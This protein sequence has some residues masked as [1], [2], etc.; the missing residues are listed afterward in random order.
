MVSAMCWFHFE[1]N[2]IHDQGLGG[3]SPAPANFACGEQATQFRCT[4]YRNEAVAH[5]ASWKSRTW[6]FHFHNGCYYVSSK[7]D[8][9]YST[10]RM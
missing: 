7:V 10:K 9:I 6:R 1:K 3:L 2:I 4:G 8:W 5:D